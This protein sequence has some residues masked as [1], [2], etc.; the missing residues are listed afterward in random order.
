MATTHRE[1][2]PLPIGPVLHG[3]TWANVLAVLLSIFYDELL[4][5]AF[6]A[7]GAILP[8]LWRAYKQG[9]LASVSNTLT[10]IIGNVVAMG[11]GNY[12]YVRHTNMSPG[13]YHELTGW[14]VAGLVWACALGSIG[15]D[16]LLPRPRA[17]PGQQRALT[18]PVLLLTTGGLYLVL[19]ILKL[20][21]VGLNSRWEGPDEAA[22]S[23]LYVVSGLRGFGTF[24]FFVLG[25]H[26]SRGLLAW[27]GVAAIGAVTVAMFI[28]AL[29]G[30]REASILMLLLTLLGA[31]AGGMSSRRLF[32]L[33]LG[34]GLVA[35]GLFVV[36]G[37]ARTDA[38]FAGGTV[39]SKFDAMRDTAS[40]GEGAPTVGPSRSDQFVS[41]VFEFTGQQVIDESRA[42]GHRAG[43]EHFERLKYLFLVA[44]IAPEKSRYPLTDGSEILER[45]YGISMGEHT[46][47]PIT[48]V[49]DAYR[50]GGEAWVLVVGLLCGVAM[51]LLVA[52]ATLVVS[53]ELLWPS[54]AL[55]AVDALRGYPHSVLGEVD[56]FAYR[57]PKLILTCV[58]L[59]LIVSAVGMLLGVRPRS[60]SHV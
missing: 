50:R 13:H 2:D 58:I 32:A 36:V 45:D 16:L 7:S 44:A 54:L 14:L 46:S 39:S 49:A 51:R 29:T 11:F 31:A 25:A 4:A 9:T 15:A 59:G 35:A 21:F 27:R 1:P 28:A 20:S 40:G 48:V 26:M 43:F 30:G 3:L 53:R 12:A 57:G 19:L 22:S 18:G 33:F 24:F 42:S 17:A 5:A 10:F 56:R 23:V 6:V 55:L 60:R 37:L 34:A 52:L 41:R 8:L 47:V 38:R